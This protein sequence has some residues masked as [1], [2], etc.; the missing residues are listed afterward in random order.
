ML[1]IKL[2][3]LTSF[4]TQTSSLNSSPDVYHEMHASEKAKIAEE[5]TKAACIAL[6]ETTGHQ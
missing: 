6:T 4:S 1:V 2:E 3:T 5:L